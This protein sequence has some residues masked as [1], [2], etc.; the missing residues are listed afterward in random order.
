MKISASD[1]QSPF[2][3]LDLMG[4]EVKKGDT[5]AIAGLSGK[6][7]QLFLG[8]FTEIK[9]CKKTARCFYTKIGISGNY[10]FPTYLSI[11]LECNGIPSNQLIKISGIEFGL[12]QK[13]F[14]ALLSIK[15]EFDA[16]NPKIEENEDD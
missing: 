7:P 15:S 9:L 13:R 12:N 10:K 14:A 8:L 6:T 16:A 3:L 4:E 11:P 1:N 2:V 5:I